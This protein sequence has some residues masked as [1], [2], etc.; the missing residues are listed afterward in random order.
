MSEFQ[1]AARELHTSYEEI[2]SRLAGRI[3]G[4]DDVTRLLVTGV[5]CGGHCLLVGVPGLAKTRLISTMSELL[6]LKF[7]RIQF[8]PD[9]MPSDITG[10]E[11]IVEDHQ[12]GERRFEFLGGPIFANIVL[13]DEINRTPPKTQAA[14]MEA[15]EERQVS[16]LGKRFE[17]EAPFFVLATQN[18]IE[19]EGTYPLPAAQ[20]DRFLFEIGVDYPSAVEE[21][22][23]LRMT[24][25]PHEATLSPVLD[26][27]QVLR[28]SDAVRRMPISDAVATYATTL[29][30]RSRPDDDEAP[31][32]IKKYLSFGAGPRAAQALVLGAKV[33][34]M[35][36]GEIDAT[37][38]DVRS[39]ARPVLPHRIVLNFM[40]A[41]DGVAIDSII[42]RLVDSVPAPDRPAGTDTVSKKGLFSFFTRGAR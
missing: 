40:G 33:Q 31:A 24:T 21:Q 20:L 11:V 22:A 9:L 38:A 34:A 42:D 6:D 16:S 29:A 2:R 1:T 35:L 30:R 28:M 26:K 3:V 32:I 10:A 8:T 7:S 37:F 27:A 4:M 23:I 5:F 13:A 41:A 14:L 39:L 12:S 36:R 15:M 18:P 19:Q 25:S 17:L